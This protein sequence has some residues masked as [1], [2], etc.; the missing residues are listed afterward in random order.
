MNF[1]RTTLRQPSDQSAQTFI[2]FTMVV[3]VLFLFMGLGIDIGFAYLTKAKMAKALDAA[4]L[5][6][7]RNLYISQDEATKKATAVFKANYGSASRDVSAPVPT[8]AYTTDANGSVNVLVTATTNIRTFFIRVLPVWKTLPV[9][10]RAAVTRGRAVVSLVLD[11]SGS[12]NG[13]GGAQNL[14][15]AVIGF[16]NL[17]SDGVDIMSESSFSYGGRTDVTM[18]HPFKALI[19]ASV[20]SMNFNG[21]TASESGLRRAME[22]N[23]TV[24]TVPGDNQVKAIVFFTDGLANTWQ[25]TFNCGDRNI[26]PSAQLYDPVT[27]SYNQS[28]CTVPAKIPSIVPSNPPV[29]TTDNCSIELE[30]EPRAEAIANQA[31]DEGSVIYAIGLGN[32]NA[33]GEC[34]RPPLNLPF[35]KRIANSKDSTTYNPDQPTGEAIVASA[36]E[37]QRVFQEVAK[38][39]LLRITQ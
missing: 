9:T 38:K 34:G 16:V 19:T 4:A 15:G 10:A 1:N 2:L 11:R 27:G 39:L 28:G 24:V 14:P 3:I 29:D 31:R 12:M 5:T 18:Q 7:G 37:L 30:A 35:L 21:Y 17:F 36:S 23:R 20:N 26:T 22:Q 32:P 8:F 33:T 25:Y 13:N 6:A